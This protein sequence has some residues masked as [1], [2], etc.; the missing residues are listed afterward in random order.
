MTSETRQEFN[1][2]E[3]QRWAITRLAE[4]MGEDLIDPGGW[5]E[6]LQSEGSISPYTFQGWLNEM[7][8]EGYLRRVWMPVPGRWSEL[9][10][11]PYE[12]AYQLTRA[13]MDAAIGYG[14]QSLGGS[15]QFEDDPADEGDP[16]AEVRE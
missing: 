15:C 4:L 16:V 1:L 2:T 12:H 7:V 3:Q 11:A 6:C 5:L 14:L 8:A 9:E 13:G 10:T